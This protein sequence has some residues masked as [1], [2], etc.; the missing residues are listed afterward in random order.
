[1]N[2]VVVNCHSRVSLKPKERAKLPGKDVMGSLCRIWGIFTCEIISQHQQMPEV[3]SEL[4]KKKPYVQNS[5]PVN[6]L[7]GEKHVYLFLNYW[8]CG[9]FCKYLSSI[10]VT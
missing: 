4:K 7:K 3:H 8:C 2:S 9:Y 1:M 10:L 5:N 6:I